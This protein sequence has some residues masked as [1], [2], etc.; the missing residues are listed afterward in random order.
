MIVPVEGLGWLARAVCGVGRIEGTD[1][2]C[3]IRVRDFFVEFIESHFCIIEFGV[4]E[5]Q[6][7]EIVEEKLLQLRFFARITFHQRADTSGVLG[8]LVTLA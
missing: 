8:P 5:V 3:D 6:P 2:M 4:V 1:V 7:G